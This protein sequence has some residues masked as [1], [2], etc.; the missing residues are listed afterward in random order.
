MLTGGYDVNYSYKENYLRVQVYMKSMESVETN[1]KIKITVSMMVIL[2]RYFS[3]K[4]INEFS[5]MFSVQKIYVCV[6][7]SVYVCARVVSY[8]I[9][10]QITLTNKLFIR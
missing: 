7:V 6:C 4:F 1:S 10:N 5:H 3:P 9:L 8:L 2:V